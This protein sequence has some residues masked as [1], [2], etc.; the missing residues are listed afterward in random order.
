MHLRVLL[1][2]H[3]APW[4]LPGFRMT[5]KL[6]LLRC[7]ALVSFLKGYLSTGRAF[8]VVSE[9]GGKGSCPPPSDVYLKAHRRWNFS[10]L[11]K[12]ECRHEQGFGNFFSA[13]VKARKKPWVWWEHEF[14]RLSEIH[15]CSCS[16]PQLSLQTQGDSWRWSWAQARVRWGCREGSQVS[17]QSFHLPSHKSAAWAGQGRFLGCGFPLS[18]SCTFCAT[19]C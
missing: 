11:E 7:V 19:G 3:Q 2:S 14:A 12:R 4:C 15:G 8:G 1:Q 16:A 13:K 10:V 9:Q 18:H 6:L 17:C 5:Q